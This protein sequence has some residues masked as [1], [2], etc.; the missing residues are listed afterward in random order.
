MII[1]DIDEEFSPIAQPNIGNWSIPLEVSTNAVYRNCDSYGINDELD[2]FYNRF[3]YP[4]KSRISVFS[5]TDN[6][7]YTG[8]STAQPSSPNYNYEDYAQIAVSYGWGN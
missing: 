2:T 7:D 8:A 6:P 5:P 4:D 3:A 1:V